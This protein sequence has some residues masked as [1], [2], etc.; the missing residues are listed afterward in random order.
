MPYVFAFDHKHRRPPMEHQ[1]PARWQ[2]RQPRR[3]DVGARAA[4]AARLHH[5]DRRLP[6]LHGT[7]AGRQGLD[8]EVAAHSPRLEKAMGEASATPPTRCSSSVRSGAK[9]S[10]PGMMDTVL[11]LGLNDDSRRGPGQADRR[12]ALRLRLLPALHR[13]VRPHRAGARRRASSTRSFDAAKELAGVDDRRRGARRAAALRSST[14]YKADRRAPHRQALPPGADGAAARRHR[15]RVPQS[16]NGA[17]AIAYRDRE[18]IAPRPRHRGQR[19]GDG[20]RQPR[21]QLAAP[22]SA[23]PATPPPARTVPTAT[24]WST[25][26]ARTSW[27]ASATPSRSRRLEGDTSP[28]C[29]RELLDDLRPPRGALPDMC[30]TEFTIEQGKLWMLQTRVGKRTGAAALRM[31]VD[32]MRPSDLGISKAE[33]VSRIT[34]DH[35]DSGAAPAVRQLRLRHLGQGPRRLARVPRWVA[36]TSP[37][38]TPPPRPSGASTSSSCA[39]RPPPRTCT[40]CSSPR[41]S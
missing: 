20:L 19:A 23:S 28:R 26:R 34:E 12:R 3:D 38:T 7:A 1:G 30:D 21:R 29:T 33:A 32:M 18:R 2:G 36:S 25:P 10:M 31:A 17:R 27:P 8:A 24:S 41:G 5:L 11:N 6:R 22:A 13:D 39:T 14:R 35:L 15:G 9:F 37:P 16:W 40:A 4:G